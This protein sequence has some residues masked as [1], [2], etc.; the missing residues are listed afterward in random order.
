MKR[1]EGHA[2]S[3]RSD[4]W[5]WVA[6]VVTGTEGGGGGE[7]GG[8]QQDQK[9]DTKCCGRRSMEAFTI[10]IFLTTSLNHNLLRLRLVLKF[11]NNLTDKA[12]VKPSAI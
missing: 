8:R 2:R 10:T 6:L 4:G 11:S 1:G 3:N 9:A 12:F 7:G 5:D